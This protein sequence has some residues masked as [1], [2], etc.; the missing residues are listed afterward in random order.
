MIAMKQDA[1]GP[2]ANLDLL[3]SLAVLA[4][5]VDHLV[6]T[7]RYCGLRV[8]DW[9]QLLTAH[10]GQAGVIAF[11]VHTSLV[12]MESLQRLSGGE[13]LRRGT[14]L[15]FYLRRF[16]RIYPLALVCITLVVVLDLPAVTWR[17]ALPPTPQVVLANQWL[18]QN[19]VTGRSVLGPLW[20]LPYEVQMYVVLPALYLLATT[21]RGPRWLG[22]L[23]GA[24]VLGALVLG[25]FTGGR[26]NMAAYLPCFLCGVICFVLRQRVRLPQWPSGGWI[27]ALAGLFGG[28]AWLHWGAGKPSAVAGWC[29]ALLLSLA[30]L[31]F[32]DSRRPRLNRCTQWIARYS[33]GL[34]LLHVPVLWLVFHRWRLQS[35][36]VGLLVYLGVS[37][38]AAVIA[39]HLVE[40]PMVA[41][42]QRLTQRTR[43][44]AAA[45]S[46]LS[47]R[48]ESGKREM[49]L[50]LAA[51]E[52]A[53]VWQM[54][55][56]H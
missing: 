22:V 24:A 34:Y 44:S 30:I 10:I 36:P 35:L 7:W 55:H 16:L 37:T 28:Y 53:E 33:Y 27:A 14:V 31:L 15:R 17:E 18:V 12:L 56:R 13:P 43:A 20:S 41:L 25:E 9:W 2:E 50:G 29:F 42:G 45:A 4:V 23:L 8:S 3:R 5:M 40:A 54:L 49:P 52:P 26:L 32:A 6:P 11:F 1:R 39:F 48:S 51:M 47:A 38:A 21:A 19:L 46:E